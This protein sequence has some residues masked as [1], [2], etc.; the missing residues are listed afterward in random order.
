MQRLTRERNKLRQVSIISKLY[1]AG[2]NG[3]L[4]R[5]Q[6]RTALHGEIGAIRDVRI[7]SKGFFHLELEM[8]VA[9]NSLSLKNSKVFFTDRKQG[10]CPNKAMAQ[11]ASC[12][13]LEP[14]SLD[15]RRTIC[16]SS[17]K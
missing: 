6:I 13:D 3:G 5:N 8:L 15:S 12:T 16:V 7:P 10:F 1:E 14:S 2:L 11:E 4:M 17:I 9:Q